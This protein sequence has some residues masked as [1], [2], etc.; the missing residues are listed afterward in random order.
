M[1]SA[2]WEGSKKESGCIISSFEALKKVSWPTDLLYRSHLYFYCLSLSVFFCLWF[3]G[4]VVGMVC[5]VFFPFFPVCL[6]K[7]TLLFILSALNFA[8]CFSSCLFP[9]CGLHV[10]LLPCKW[11]RKWWA[12]TGYVRPVW[13]SNTWAASATGCMK[14]YH[15]I[16]IMVGDFQ[17]ATNSFASSCWSTL[18]GGSWNMSRVMQI[19]PLPWHFFTA[20]HITL[21]FQPSLGV[22]N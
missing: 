4:L 8:I 18:Q 17:G 19:Y 2:L 12:W 3:V 11:P 9:G 16:R 14:R 21:I 13:M 5:G 20:L 1:N 22:L 15:G 6:L 7:T 10:F